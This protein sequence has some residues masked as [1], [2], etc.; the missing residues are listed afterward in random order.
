MQ[1]TRRLT[2]ERRGGGSIVFPLV[3]GT[4]AGQS[5]VACE[6]ARISVYNGACI[7]EREGGITV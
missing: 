4:Y 1:Q 3:E 6:V 5:D 7:V 2:G